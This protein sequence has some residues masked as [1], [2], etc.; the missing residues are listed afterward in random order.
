M[1][2]GRLSWESLSLSYFLKVAFTLASFSCT[3][4]SRMFFSFSSGILA[5]AAWATFFV[6]V[7][8]DMHSL[9]IVL[10][11]FSFGCS[12]SFGASSAAASASP[13]FASPPS[14]PSAVSA[15]PSAASA[16]ASPS[17]TS[18]PSVAAASASAFAF[19]AAASAAARDCSA[20]E[21]KLHRPAQVAPGWKRSRL[22]YASADSAL[23]KRSAMP[24][25]Y[26][27]RQPGS[28]GCL[29]TVPMYSATTA[30]SPELAFT[31]AAAMVP[32]ECAKAFCAPE[33]SKPSSGADMAVWL[34]SAKPETW[35]THSS[36]TWARVLAT[37][38]G[39]MS[40]RER[41]RKLRNCTA[42]AQ[43]AASATA[44]TGAI[45]AIVAIGC[46]R[47]GLR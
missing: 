45:L 7:S 17:A 18:A 33:Q 27:W 38:S 46:P 9:S 41:P 34:H 3:S 23:I 11:S 20:A 25:Q 37:T 4:T 30:R 21:T 28:V 35:L 19:A 2:S 10:A 1:I 12:S 22:S 29:Q 44:A 39:R 26:C 42:E 5:A 13:S 15:A 36:S 16:G 14:P 32:Q 40:E 31:I 6:S 8:L 24:W 47:V 43:P